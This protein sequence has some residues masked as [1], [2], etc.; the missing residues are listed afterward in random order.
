MSSKKL[1]TVSAEALRHDFRVSDNGGSGLGGQDG[2]SS[3]T[4]LLARTAVALWHS[5]SRTRRGT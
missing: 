5:G 4:L 1:L 3:T 2:Q